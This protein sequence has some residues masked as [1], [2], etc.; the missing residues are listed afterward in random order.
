MTTRF[1]DDPEFA[2]DDPLA[3]ILRPPAEHLGPPPGRYAAVRRAAARRRLLRAA[4]GA[5]LT[6]AVAALVALPLHLSASSAPA[7]PTVP[8]APPS[9]TMRTPAPSATPSPVRTTV[10]T[11]VPASQDAGPGR[12]TAPGD[13]RVPPDVRSRDT[14]EPPSRTASGA[15]PGDA[16]ASERPVHR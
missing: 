12:V 4:A 3:V 11:P 10:P 16:P 2:P 13:P 5:G 8:L 7:S 15:A 1:D 6:C 14:L 9:S